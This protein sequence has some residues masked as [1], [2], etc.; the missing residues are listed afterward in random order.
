MDRN[1]QSEKSREMMKE[2]TYTRL[3]CRIDVLYL[4]FFIPYI[5]CVCVRT[6]KFDEQAQRAL[7][8]CPARDHQ[9]LHWVQP[10]THIQWRPYNIRP[11]DCHSCYYSAESGCGILLL[12]LDIIITIN[13]RS[14]R[15]RRT[16]ARPSDL[17]WIRVRIRGWR[18][19]NTMR[20][21]FHARQR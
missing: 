21:L 1:K 3:K 10:K 6:C 15:P 13:D 5:V 11:F 16:R 9:T 2:P 19:L 20:L 17:V 14:R 18:R 7:F 4:F 8:F 12:F